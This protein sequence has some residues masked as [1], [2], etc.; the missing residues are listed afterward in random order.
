MLPPPSCKHTRSSEI[1]PIN[2]ICTAIQK[3]PSME[4]MPMEQ[5]I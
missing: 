5:K 2:T 4:S 1:Q 3:S